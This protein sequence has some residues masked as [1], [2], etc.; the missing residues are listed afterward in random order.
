[1]KH[2][3]IVLRALSGATLASLASIPLRVW[4][5]TGAGTSSGAGTGASG[6]ARLL[7]SDPQAL[8]LGYKDDSTHVDQKKF[9][10]H[11]ATQ[12][13]SGCQF[14]QGTA[15]DA[16]APCAIFAGK[17]VAAKGWCSSYIKKAGSS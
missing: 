12:V 2:R 3:R 8:S 11:Q 17:K 5:Q 7:E 4:A 14:Y 1:M 15:Q 16:T 13:C 6:A 10:N 9:P